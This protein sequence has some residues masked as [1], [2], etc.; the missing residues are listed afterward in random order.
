MLAGQ[1]KCWSITVNNRLMMAGGISA[2]TYRLL[3]LGSRHTPS[4]EGNLL[5][6]DEYLIY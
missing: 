2:Q 1:Y 4:W 6:K 3:P 5:F